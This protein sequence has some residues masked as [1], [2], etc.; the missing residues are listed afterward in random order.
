MNDVIFSFFYNCIL[1]L[2]F[3]CAL[4]RLLYMRV[5]Y[6]KY[7]Q[8]LGQRLGFGY[9]SI[10]KG[11]RQLIWIHAVSVGEV[12]AVAALAKMLKGKLGNPLL[13][14][15]TTTETGQAEA[16]RSVPEADFY[17]YLPFDFSWIIK[18]IVRKFK[19]DVVILTESDFWYHF[20]QV[21]K[22]IGAK[23][24]LVNGKLSERSAKRFKW[25]PWFTSRLF[26]LF[27]C[28][29]LQGDVYKRR[30]EALGI[31]PEKLFVTG[32]MKFDSHYPQLSSVELDQ[33]MQRMG[34]TKGQPTLV[35]GSTH[36]PEEELFIPVLVEL[37]KR[38][39]QLKVLLV[40]RHPERFDA[41]AK[42]L[43]AHQISFS[44]DSQH[45]PIKPLILVDAM[46][47]LRTCYQLATV[48]VVAGSFTPVV[49]GHHILE[50]CWYGVPVVFGP[51]MHSQPDMV[52]LALEYKVGLQVQ[53]GELFESLLHLFS[54]PSYRDGM[55]RSGIKLSQDIKGATERT[56]ERIS[57]I[58]ANTH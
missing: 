6:G 24:F 48:A 16:R 2:V 4:P 10:N 51:Y 33:L 9:P 20:L 56:F 52:D 11:E 7:R 26:N 29:C 42:L 25:V 23:V 55:S 22:E 21:S 50:P 57:L 41:V 37:W 19:P 35:I 13:L 27:D 28:L 44:R 46:G 17:F 14:M 8:S 53:E 58:L 40:P 45:N 3:L 54:D 1:L 36:A 15:T 31:Q 18:P 39:P 43:D 12:K 34:V 47:V 32:N 49:G 38:I 5:R 30:F